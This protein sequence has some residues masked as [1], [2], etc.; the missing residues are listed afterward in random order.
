MHGLSAV[1]VGC[2][3]T[4]DALNDLNDLTIAWDIDVNDDSNEDGILDNDADLIGKSVPTPS[5]KTVCNPSR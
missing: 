4:L 1:F 2:N 3:S 5:N